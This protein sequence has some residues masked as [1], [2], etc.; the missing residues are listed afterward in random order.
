MK[1][2]LTSACFSLIMVFSVSGNAVA[3]NHGALVPDS[4][5]DAMTMMLDNAAKFIETFNRGN[6]TELADLYTE[7]AIQSGTNMTEPLYGR[8]A[9]K[10][11]M[12]KN[13]DEIVTRD[14]LSTEVFTAHDLGNGYIAANGSWEI[15]DKEGARV[16]GGLWSNLYRVVDG[17]MLMFRESA[18]R[19]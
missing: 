3:D 14:I 18:S 6:I 13:A 2:N 15:H 9:I 10:A 8:A 7:D 5:S 17:E 19:N 16:R 12:E 1:S 4:H 11:S